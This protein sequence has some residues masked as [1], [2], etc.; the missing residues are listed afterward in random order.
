VLSVR[1]PSRSAKIGFT[2]N[3][4][5]SHQ[6]PDPALDGGDHDQDDEQLQSAVQLGQRYDYAVRGMR[7]MLAFR[8]A[9]QSNHCAREEFLYELQGRPCGRPP[10]AL[11][12]GDDTVVTGGTGLTLRIR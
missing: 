9:Q 8:T 1:L 11:R 4:G 12:P 10:A 2:L 5:P 3:P 7:G 6:T